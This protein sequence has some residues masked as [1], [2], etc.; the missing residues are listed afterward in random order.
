MH[1][2]TAANVRGL[3][4]ADVLAQLRAAMPPTTSV[5][6]ASKLLGISQAQGYALAKG[7]EFPVRAIRVGSRYRVLTA[8]LLRLLDE[9]NPLEGDS[10]DD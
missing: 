8:P 9:D 3:A 2:D 10:T 1:T 5:A 7:G 4:A 6:V